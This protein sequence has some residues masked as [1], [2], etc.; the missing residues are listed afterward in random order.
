MKSISTNNPILVLGAA[1][2]LAAP[3]AGLL[4]RTVPWHGWKCRRANW[5]TSW[6]FATDRIG[7]AGKPVVVVV[8]SDRYQAGDWA[9]SH[10]IFAG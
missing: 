3:F 1:A 10:R 2:F 6:C 9:R 4:W 7:Y 5:A 8:V